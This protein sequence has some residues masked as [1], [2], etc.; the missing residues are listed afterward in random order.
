SRRRHTRFSRDWSSDVCS[1]DLFCKDFLP[2]K[3][4]YTTEYNVHDLNGLILQCKAFAES[5]GLDITLFEALDSHRKFVLNPTS[6]DSY[7]VPKFNSEV[8]SCLNTLKELREIKNEPFLKRGEQV[9]F[10]LTDDGQNTYKFEI[11]LEDDFR[12]LKEPGK[13]AV[14]SKGMVNYWVTK[15]GTKGDLQHKQD[16]LKKMYDGC[17]SKS[18]KTKSA[19]FWE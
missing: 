2:K 4:H 8:G 12:L 19:D 9:E 7:D 16:T 14:I 1:S 11:K 3:Y 5:G 13:D 6:H 17:Y 18:N 10:E 15:N